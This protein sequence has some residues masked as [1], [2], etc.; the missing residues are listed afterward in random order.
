MFHCIP[1]GLWAVLL[2]LR[3]KHFGDIQVDF[4]QELATAW[5]IVSGKHL[6]TDIAYFKGPLSPHWNALMF[7]LFGTSIQTLTVVNALLA[8]FAAYGIVALSRRVV[9]PE[10]GV[11]LACTFL[12]YAAFSINGHLLNIY[13]F[14]TPFVHELTHGWILSLFLILS[15]ERWVERPSIHRALII[16]I[17]FGGILLTRVE[18]A[19]AAIGALATWIF[20]VACTKRRTV[21][22]LHGVVM[23]SAA[24]TIIV[25]A[26]IL[27]HPFM[28]SWSDAWRA[29][30]ASVWAL[31]G[32]SVA[33]T[34]FFQMVSGWN[35]PVENILLQVSFLCIF[36]GTLLPFILAAYSWERSDAVLSSITLSA[37]IAMVLHLIYS[38]ILLLIMS[39][40]L[41]LVIIG[42]LAVTCRQWLKKRDAAPCRIVLVTSVFSFLMLG[43]ILLAPSVL[44]YGFSHGIGAFLIILGVVLHSVPHIAQ[45]AL[46]LHG[47][48]A[49][50]AS[51]FIFVLLILGAKF[52]NDQIEVQRLSLPIGTGRDQIYLLDHPNTHSWNAFLSLAPKLIP[53]GST[54]T[55]IPEG[56]G[57]NY[58]L[59]IEP[60]VPVMNFMYTEYAI[61]GRERIL[62]DF[63]DRTPEYIVVTQKETSDFGYPFFGKDDAYGKEVMDWLHQHYVHVVTFGDEPLQNEQSYGVALWRRKM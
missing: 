49:L 36:L 51:V 19:V 54:M 3:W 29:T 23:L 60:A 14:I 35:A 2:I 45:K 50:R 10:A 25:A 1:F 55:V 21:I 16:G 18:I 27:L 17:L 33:S 31:M 43:K 32:T 8:L 46:K 48:H 24:M 22:L 41:T 4:G 52:A 12:I 30:F 53:P 63:L 39:G 34:P 62:Q 42:I 58:L 9:S 7:L 6:Y 59:R 11:L 40:F 15:L 28:P 20:C 5:Q 37:G 26:V 57:L 47:V 44:F 13:N 38:R 61:F 56:I